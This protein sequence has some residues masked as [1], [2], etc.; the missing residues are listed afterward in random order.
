[1]PENNE[2]FNNQSELLRRERYHSL[3]LATE[4]LS[5]LRRLVAATD[6]NG[7]KQTWVALLSGKRAA[8]K[9]CH[10]DDSSKLTPQARVSSSLHAAE[11][12]ALPLLAQWHRKHQPELTVWLPSSVLRVLLDSLVRAPRLQRVVSM[13]TTEPTE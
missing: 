2:R 4:D 8:I 3:P 6:T 7:A 11:R 5:N 13:E 10:A 12:R 9:Q 1:M